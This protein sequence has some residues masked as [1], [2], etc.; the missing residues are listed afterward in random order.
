MTIYT[1]RFILTGH[2]RLRRTMVRPVAPTAKCD[3][4]PDI[5]RQ[6]QF[7]HTAYSLL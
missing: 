3:T 7:L 2:H 5:I 6:L 4:N 1:K